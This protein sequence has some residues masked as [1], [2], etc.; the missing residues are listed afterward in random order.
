MH[1]GKRHGSDR[2]IRCSARARKRLTRFAFAV[3]CEAC[4]VGRSGGLHQ[5]AF[6]TKER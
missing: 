6:N 3:G 4:G 2:L 1:G 5:N